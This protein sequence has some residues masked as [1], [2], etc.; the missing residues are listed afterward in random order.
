LHVQGTFLHPKFSV[1]AGALIRGGAAIAL[2]VVNPLAALLPL[3]ETGPGDD[4][5]CLQVL[6]PVA[7]ALKQATQKSK[8][9]PPVPAKK[10]RE[11]TVSN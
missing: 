9:P 4:A 8:Q 10:S 7:P 2:G 5:N 11:R 6:A 1:G 3:I